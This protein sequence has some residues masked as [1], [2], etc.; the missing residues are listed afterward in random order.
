MQ[1]LLIPFTNAHTK[2]CFL[3]NSPR[4]K[5][6]EARREVLDP[7]K[8]QVLPFNAIYQGKR[9]ELPSNT[10]YQ[11]TNQAPTSNANSRGK[12]TIIAF[13]CHLPRQNPLKHFHIP[14]QILVKHCLLLPCTMAKSKHGLLKSFT[15]AQTW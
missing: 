5:P 9:Q 4:H 12:I 2:H 10:I 14:M 15:K 3:C 11:S 6:G 13:S 8:K 7:S 1:C